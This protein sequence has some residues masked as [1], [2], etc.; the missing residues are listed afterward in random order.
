MVRI[1]VRPSRM[2]VLGWLGWILRG[3]LQRMNCRLSVHVG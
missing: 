3:S 1:V 2:T